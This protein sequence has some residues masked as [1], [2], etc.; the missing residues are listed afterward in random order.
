MANYLCVFSA[1]DVHINF[2]AENPESLYAYV[3]GH[4]PDLNLPTP[5]KKTLWQRLTGKVPSSETPSELPVDWPTREASMFG[6]EINHLNVDLYHL[7]LNGT[8]DFVTG[9]GSI[10]QTWLQTPYDNTHSAIDLTGDNENFAFRS[11]QLPELL[12]LLSSIEPDKVRECYTQ[13]LSSVGDDYVPSS[14]ECSDIAIEISEFTSAIREA[15]NKS[16]GLIWI[17]S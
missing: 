9:S 13:W 12:S 16:H 17:C 6:P 15:V 14:S 5:P 4:L 7:I 11:N 8:T 10:F 3:E 2:I 1:P